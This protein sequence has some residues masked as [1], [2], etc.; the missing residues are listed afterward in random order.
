[1][2][3]FVAHGLFEVVVDLFDE[4]HNFGRLGVGIE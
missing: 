2:G 1:V 4:V 3:V